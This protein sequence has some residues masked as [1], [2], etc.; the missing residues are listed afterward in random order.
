MKKVAIYV[1]ESRD[2]LGL[3]YETIETQKSLLEKFVEEKG[4]GAVYK[5]YED[6]NY[7]GINFE[8]PGIKKLIE[9]AS[10]GKF[11]ILVAKDLSRLGRSNARTLLF[12][13]SV[14]E[15][16]VRVLTYDGRY[17]SLRDAETVGI[18][19]WFNERYVIDISRKIRA[20]LRHKIER[21]EYIGNPPYGYVK[22]KDVRNRLEVCEEEALVV[23]EIYKLYLEGYG[24][25]KISEMLNEEGIGK[26]KWNATHI[27]RI[28]TSRVYV[29]DTVQGVS[30]RVSY[31]SKKTRRLPESEW[32]LTENTHE[33]IVDEETFAKVQK[34]RER[35]QKGCGN[36]KGALSVFKGLV[37][38]ADCNKRMYSRK[39]TKGLDGYTCQTYEK[40]GRAACSRH[41]VSEC[42]L[43]NIVFSDIYTVLR[44]YVKSNPDC[45][46]ELAML[47]GER[48][49]EIG[50]LRNLVESSMKKQKILYYDRLDGRI[51]AD[52]YDSMNLELESSIERYKKE[53]ER[54]ERY[55][56][57][58]KK[59]LDVLLDVI[60]SYKDLSR[61]VKRKIVKIVVEKITVSEK[62]IC[63]WY[64]L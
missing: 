37:Y 57:K 34:E 25:K 46:E 31:K 17:D 62:E 3:S 28:L 40:Q 58:N 26:K 1:R 51:S 45:I 22:S 50:V 53:I 47:N 61:E 35:R 16:G 42:F 11:D 49:R 6:D 10:C 38:C 13:E 4:L 23:R 24:Y 20:N 32:V 33:P 48:D 14:E 2:D 41:F 64:C 39:Q 30:E 19:S 29:G 12:L 8:R 52:M 56:D 9:D 7:S 55:G 43:S 44:D 18:D 60:K 21:G 36:H 5:I 27:K 59:S 63:I 15:F 54:L